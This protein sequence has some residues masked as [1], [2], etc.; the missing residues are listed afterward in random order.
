MVHFLKTLLQLQN[1][2]RVRGLTP[3]LPTLLSNCF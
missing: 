3:P 2:G 1:T